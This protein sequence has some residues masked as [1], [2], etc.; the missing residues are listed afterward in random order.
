MLE[1]AEFRKGILF[2]RLTGVIREIESKELNY[3]FK[4]LVEESGIKYIALNLSGLSSIN[5]GGIALLDQLDKKIKGNG[6]N[7]ILCGASDR[8][9]GK[10]RKNSLFNICSSTSELNVFNMINI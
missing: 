4:Y 6:G 2:L 9:G 3:Y 5:K 7:L 10:I 1:T 8:L